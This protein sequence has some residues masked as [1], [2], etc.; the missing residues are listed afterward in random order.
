MKK[1]FDYFNLE[2]ELDDFDIIHDKVEKDI[3]FKGTN[4]WILVFA[5]FVA[6]IGLN[7]NSTA[8]IIGAML[9]SPLMGPINGMGYSVATYDFPLFKTALKNFGFAV[10]ASLLASTLY[11][12]ISPV[13][14]AHSEL[15]ARTSPTIYDVLIAFF[16]GLAGIVAISSKQKGNVLP[17]VAIATALMP[18]LC[19]A[20]YGLATGNFYFFF[21][22]FYLF[23]INTVFIAL[24]SALV[25]QLLKFPIRAQIDEKRKRSVN[26]ILSFIILITIIPSIYFGYG[27]VQNEKFTEKSKKFVESITVFEGNYLLKSN[28]DASKKVLT[29]GFAGNLLDQNYKSKVYKKANDFGLDSTNI[30]FQKALTFSKV[31]DL[32]KSENLQ[33][34]INRLQAFIESEKRNKDSINSFGNQILKEANILYP[35][36]KE[37]AFSVTKNYSVQDSV[38]K[39]TV[40]SFISTK[41]FDTTEKKRIK[42]W[43]VSRLN[44]ENIKI[45]IEEEEEK[46]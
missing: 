32:T 1:I 44:T 9:I 13:S 39:I 6:S 27:L 35:E 10:V 14:A 33:G 21:G 41:N 11:F 25:C 29:L 20:G 16:G 4:L 19:T 31:S 40:V 37:C 2:R 43:L 18:P 36:I 15:L 24:S 30:V 5:I 38:H 46:K 34:E 17:G 42:N 26:Q 22:A 23:T 3:S 8:V 45:S 12:T 7:M 28:I